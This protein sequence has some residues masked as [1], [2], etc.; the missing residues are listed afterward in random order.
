MSAPASSGPAEAPWPAAWVRAALEP[1]ILGSLAAGPLHG[2]GIA[3]ALAARGFGQLRGG[4]LYPILAR[5][6]AAG[7]V[8]AAGVEGQAGPGRKDYAITDAGRAAYLA[9]VA[10]WERLGRA[11][12][13]PATQ[14]AAPSDHPDTLDGGPR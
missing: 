8:T 4:S 13:E 6:E 2:Y 11:L 7:H 5:L 9:A 1:A 10:D 12:A 3:Q 14:A